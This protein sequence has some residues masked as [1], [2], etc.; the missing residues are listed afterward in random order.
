MRS[1]LARGSGAGGGQAAEISIDDDADQS[2]GAAP[3]RCLGQRGAKDCCGGLVRRRD[4]DFDAG[5][6]GPHR[7]RA[8]AIDR[9]YGQ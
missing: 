8:D 1:G 9:Q 2:I 6:A 3:A 4:A 5:G 7:G